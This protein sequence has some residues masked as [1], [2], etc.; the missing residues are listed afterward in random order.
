VLVTDGEERSALAACRALAQANRQVTVVAKTRLASALWSRSCRTRVVGPDP[1]HDGE[2]FVQE[3]ARILERETHAALLPGSEASLLAISKFR[4][5]LEGVVR[6]GLPPDD[7]VRRS[8]DKLLL[9]REARAAGL[10]PPPSIPCR[11]V[12]EAAEAT[13]ELGLPVILKPGRTLQPGAD[14]LRQQPVALVRSETDLNEK[15][16]AF[17]GP[18]VVQKFLPEAGRFSAAGVMAE[19]RLLALAIT[20]FDRTWPARAGAVAFG[21]TV[22]PPPGLAEKIEPLLRRIGWSGIFELEYLELPDGRARVIDLNPR[23]FGWLTLAVE[24]GAN[25]PAVW[26]D[27]VLG[28]DPDAVTA[29]PGVRYRW[30]EAELAHFFWQLRHGEMA[31]AARVVRPYRH[32]V[33]AHFRMRDPA[34]LLAQALHLAAAKH[35]ARSGGKVRTP[36]PSDLRPGG[37]SGNG[38][39]HRFGRS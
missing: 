37:R 1:K 15:L 38:P 30:E 23:I 16:A 18:F 9:L 32:V 6:L 17:D 21:E 2:S 34:P 28:R 8:L 25:L 10:D 3:L 13:R 4:S 11:E 27:W 5:V 29:R 39:L 19:E 22:M 33:R 12:S 20:R 26:C 7:A 35:A 36:L 24:A 31:A 14:G